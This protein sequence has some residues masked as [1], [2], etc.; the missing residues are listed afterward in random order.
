MSL[1]VSTLNTFGNVKDNINRCFSQSVNQTGVSSQFDHLVSIPL[2]SIPDGIKQARFN[3]YLVEHDASYGVH[4]G[5]L[6][7][8]LLDAAENWVAQEM[9]R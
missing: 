4:N 6:A 5:Y 1:S 2:E 9:A 7:G 3:L 8:A